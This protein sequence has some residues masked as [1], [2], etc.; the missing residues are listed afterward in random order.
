MK[1]LFFVV[2]ICFVMVDFVVWLDFFFECRFSIDFLFWGFC[3]GVLCCELFC[4]CSVN[5]IVLFWGVF[6][7]SY[8]MMLILF[9]VCC[10]F[11]VVLV[12]LKFFVRIFEFCVNYICI[13]F[14]CFV[15][16]VVKILCLDSVLSFLL[17][18]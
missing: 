6:V 10:D 17:L 18:L 14:F 1:L 3:L 5:N 12:N 15:C 2:W 16:L 7:F 9:L 8:L 4:I 13:Y 11:V